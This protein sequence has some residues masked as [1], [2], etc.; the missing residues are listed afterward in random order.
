ML[1]T[2]PVVPLE[3][4][5][6]GTVRNRLPHAR[7]VQSHPVFYLP[8]DH[9]KRPDKAE[10]L[11][12]IGPDNRLHPTAVSIKPDEQ[13]ADDDRNPERNIPCTEYVGLQDK[14]HEIEPRRRTDN[15]REQ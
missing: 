1:R 6:M 4:T 15:F 7:H 10:R 8:D 14:H 12:R 13:D 3:H 11:Q 5:K 2:A 9:H